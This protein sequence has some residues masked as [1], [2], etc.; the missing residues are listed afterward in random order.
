MPLS[1]VY[2][3]PPALRVLILA[4]FFVRLLGAVLTT[5]ANPNGS[6]SGRTDM[7]H[8][9]HNNRNR[10]TRRE[11]Q[12]LT[13]IGEGK[14]SKDIAA[15]LG[16]SVAT[17]SSHRKQICRKYGLHSTSALICRALAERHH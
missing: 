12:V 16:I 15:F 9:E 5:I 1:S 8:S 13:L 10:L 17:V 11:Q 3:G 14:R 7:N 2:V 4:H 6:H